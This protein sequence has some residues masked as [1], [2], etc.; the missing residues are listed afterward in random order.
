MA[1]LATVCQVVYYWFD[2]S[3]YMCILV[4]FS[5]SLLLIYSLKLIKFTVF[6]DKC[7][8]LEKILSLG[9]FLA[10][11]TGIYFLDQKFDIDYGFAGILVSVFASLFDFRGVDAPEF[12]KKLDNHFVRIA[13]FSVGLLLLAISAGGIQYYSLFAIILLL[14]YSGK[15]GKVNMKYFFYLFYP[16]H[17]VILEFIYIA[18]YYL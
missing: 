6:S 3:L 17:L 13:S 2:R 8:N 15:R 9:L 7:K 18:I 12:I 5:L 14:L 1:S 10:L 16:L 11:L 4:T